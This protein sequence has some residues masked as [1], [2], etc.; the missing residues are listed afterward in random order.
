MLLPLVVSLASADTVLDRIHDA[1]STGGITADEAALYMVLSVRDRDALPV[2]FTDGAVDEPCGTPAVVEAERML[3]MISVPVRDEVSRNLARPTLSGPEITFISPQD[4]FRIHYTTEGGDAV[5]ESYANAVAAAADYSWHVQCEEMNYFCPPPDAGMGGC[6]RYDVYIMAIDV[7]GYTSSGGEFKPPDSTHNAS[8]SHIVMSRNM[9]E[10]LLKAT[11][12]HEFQHA[13]QMAYDYT[14][15]VWFMENCAV[16]M[17]E[18]VYPET[19]DYMMYLGGGDNPIRKPWWD[20]RSGGG[21]NL[22]W[23]GGVTWAFYMWQGYDVEAVRTVW[24]NCAD[25]RGANMLEAIQDMFTEYG[26]PFNNAFMEYGYWRWFVADNWYDGGMYFAEAADWA[27]NPYVF[28]FHNFS[29]LP[30]SGDEGVY[31]PETFG[32]HWIKVNL[33]NY[34]GGWVNFS[35]DGRDGFDWRLGAILWDTAGN[36]QFTWLNAESPSGLAEVAVP[37]SGWDYAIFFP[38]MLS[39]TTLTMNY[40][41]DITYSQDVEGGSPDPGAGI[42]L[43]GNPM[44]P[45]SQVSF[46]IPRPGYVRLDLYDLSGRL[47]SALARGPMEAGLHTAGIDD[48]LATGS[49][50]L[51]LRHPEGAETVKVIISR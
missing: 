20:I 25:V 32:L 47:V 44:A 51:M 49:Y 7:L 28:S 38:A 24:N 13:V 1:L 4:H 17:E 21:S 37:T 16:F 27:G 3:G 41:F 42:T 19:D 33:E 11:M 40:T 14:E 15:P 29:S 23:Y 46:S 43:P 9:G 50:F 12:A 6:N 22:Y 35:F 39:I 18:M 26:T 5:P 36:S 2:H 8:A 31:A 10:N 30:A 48:G 34:Q 45:G